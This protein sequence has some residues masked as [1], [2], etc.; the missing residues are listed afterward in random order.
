MKRI[1]TSILIAVM[2]ITSLF[3]F[4]ACEMDLSQLPFDIPIG[5]VNEALGNHTWEYYMTVEEPTCSKNGVDFYFCSDCGLLKKI[6]TPT[7]EHTYGN[8]IIDKHPTATENGSRHKVC[9]VCGYKSDPET[10]S[11]TDEMTYKLGMGIVVDLN[12]SYGNRAQVNSTVATVVLDSAGRIVLCRIDVARNQMDIT[13]ID[14]AKTFETNMELGDNYNMAKYGQYMDW[15]GDGIVKEWYDQAKAFEKHVVGM[16]GEQVANMAT[17][18]V[19]GS[20]FVISA[21]DALLSA[22][23]TIQITE[24]K[25]AVVKACNDEQGMTFT[26]IPGSFTLGVAVNSYVE[27]AYYNDEIRIY[28]D[29]ACAVVAD[30]KILATLNDGIQPRVRFTDDIIDSMHFNGT[31]REQKEYFG[32]AGIV[33]SNNDGIMLEWY[34]QSAAFSKH[35]VGMTA[36]EVENMKTA[37]NFL[38]YQMSTDDAL[39]SAGCTIDITP[40]KTVLAKAARYAR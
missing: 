14:P 18:V 7:L 28:S 30:G 21:D 3:T 34:L 26:A 11:T 8:W 1:I 24:F 10:M 39:L 36:A 20:G 19:E 32:M 16:T 22:G 35:V 38:G 37:A 25:A 31:K 29:F 6:D 27:E 23:C 4:S 33:D 40:L 9:L 5:G 12:E 13:N 2:L 15:N 17:K